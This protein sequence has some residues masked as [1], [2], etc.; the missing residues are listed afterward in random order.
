MSLPRTIL[1]LLYLW[2]TTFTQIAAAFNLEKITTQDG[3]LGDGMMCT[4]QD[5]TGNVWIGTVNGLNYFDGH[6]ILNCTVVDNGKTRTL[7]EPVN[8]IA[9]D[10]SNNLW[11]ASQKGLLRISAS[12]RVM[13]RIPI[14]GNAT[15]HVSALCFDKD[16]CLFIATHDDGLYKLP[17]K[18]KTAQKVS[19]GTYDRA[20]MLCLAC[21]EG[22]SIYIGYQGGGLSVLSQ[23]ENTVTN[24]RFDPHAKNTLPGNEVLDILIDSKKRIWL[25]T[26]WGLTLYDKNTKTFTTIVHQAAM[27]SSLSDSDIHALAEINGQLWIGTWRGGVN[28]LDLTAFDR[29]K[30]SETTFRKIWPGDNDTELSSASVTSI[31]QDGFGNIWLGCFGGGMNVIAHQEPLFKAIVY[32]PYKGHLSGLSDKSLLTMCIGTDGR[33]WTGTDNGNIDIL[34]FDADL[35]NFTKVGSRKMSGGVTALLSDRSGKIWMAVDKTG[36]QRHDP[37]T[38]SFQSVFMNGDKNYRTYIHQIFEDS[39]SNIWVGTHDGLFVVDKTTLKAF[40]PGNDLVFNKPIS[41]IAQDCNGGIWFA[42][43]HQLFVTGA[44]RSIKE[45]NIGNSYIRSIYQDSYDRMWLTLSEGMIRFDHLKQGSYDYHIVHLNNNPEGNA[46]RSILEDGNHRFWVATN[47]GISLLSGKNDSLINF[48]TTDGIPLGFFRNG[49]AAMTADGKLLFGQSKAICWYDSNRRMEQ[50]ALAAPCI[51]RFEVDTYDDFEL[52]QFSLPVRPQMKLD[53]GQNTFTVSFSLKDFAL[54]NKVEYAYSLTG[55][56]GTWHVIPDQLNYATFRNVAWGKFTIYVK[57]R[58]INRPWSENIASIQVRIAPPPYLSVWAWCAYLFLVAVLVVV[59]LHFYK[60]RLRL[61]GTIEVERQT[62]L[63]EQALNNE[64][65]GFFTNVTHEL[66][67]PLTL[68]LGPLED[69]EAEDLNPQQHSKVS[70]IHK[71]AKRLYDLVNQIMEFRK[72]ETRNRVLTVSKG[73]LSVLIH[74]ITLKY[75]ELNRN[76]KIDIALLI[77]DSY[78]IFFDKEVVTIIVDNL[79]SNS[80]KYTAEGMVEVRLRQ[81]EENKTAYIEISVHDTGYGIPEEAL[82]HIFER[83]YQA[84]GEH[85]TVGTGIGLALVKNLVELHEGSISVRSKVGEGTTFVV[86]LKKDNAY[87]DAIH[88]V[89]KALKTTIGSTDS[90]PLLLIVEDND[91]IK[92]YISDSL[93]HDFE[94]LLANN[95]HKGMELAVQRIP[96]LIVSDIMMPIMD[97]LELT[98]SLKNDARTSHIPIILLTAK[99]EEADK[100]EGYLHGAD[101]Y[102]TKPFSIQLLKSRIANI[103]SNR[104]TIADYFANGYKKDVVTKSVNELDRAFMNKVFK[105]IE[106]NIQTEQINVSV[107]ADSVNMSYSSFYRKLKALSGVTANELIKK[108]KM[109][110]AEKMLLTRKYTLTDIMIAVG[111][112]SRTAFRE[113]FKAEFGVIPSKYLENITSPRGEHQ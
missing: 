100:T 77:E 18:G 88:V 63:K 62:R 93:S 94:I 42:T 1:C 87:P 38:G 107:L 40:R 86:R 67:T 13:N 46:I 92:Q 26:H 19:L 10:G 23:K 7:T 36:L 82:P 111:Y 106:D 89:Q 43:N 6:Q 3:L 68:I 66:R 98:D 22:N 97:G 9:F 8:E 109:Q 110:R 65:L 70:M 55:K 50:T 58:L 103:L 73:D 2:S 34:A 75:K 60:R 61:K 45:I 47:L 112:N 105:A 85:Q 29:S 39:Q 76:K 59:V 104:K 74:E 72:S 78:N 113:A 20:V 28:I 52:K 64:R 102:I 84:K 17:L 44:D 91:D 31:F 56:A 57:A 69:L 48:G 41:F 37:Q 14:G 96:D 21:D 11:V 90:K 53:Y 54:R 108:V 5:R 101:S 95:G 81:T 71:N 32:S 30:A 99:N 24:F 12:D 16:S 25:A 49:C 35:G 4:A 15:C 80:L 83:Y 79:L 27:A 33:V 51:A